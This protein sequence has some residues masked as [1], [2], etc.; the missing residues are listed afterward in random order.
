MI[1]HIRK[2]VDHLEWADARVLDSLRAGRG[3][4]PRAMALYAHVLGAEEVWLSRLESRGPRSAV[5]PS[6]SLDE[7]AAL[8]AQNAAALRALIA[9]AT[10]DDLARVVDY[11]NS[12]GQAFRSTVE[13]ILL[14]VALHGAYH[15]GQV[16]LLVRDG[17]SEPSATDYIAFA[18]GAPAATRVPA[19]ARP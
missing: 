1:D 17:G 18:R 10:V 16:A 13:D 9:A 3:S 12:A 7:A 8:A 5:W 6:L 19:P 2:L 11:R 15:R 4:H 14:H